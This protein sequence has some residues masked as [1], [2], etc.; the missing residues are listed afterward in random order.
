MKK[1]GIIFNPMVEAAGALAGELERYL[2][3]AGVS[4][5]S[6]S[7]WELA[8]I[9]PEVSGTDLVLSVGGDGTILRA[10]Q[11]V[12]A[13]K[14]PIT[15]I[16]LGKLGFMTELAADEALNRLPE[17]LDGAGWLDERAMLEAQITGNG[18]EGKIYYA[19]NDVVVARGAIARLVSVEA[20][21]DDEPL[22]V[23][24]ADGVMV[25]TATGSTGYALAAGGPV[26]SPEVTELLLLPILP[27]LSLSYPLVLPA[28]AVVSLRVSTAYRATLS[29]DGNINLPLE[30]GALIT[31]KRSQVITRFWRIHPRASFYRSLEQKLKGKK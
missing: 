26:L 18:G 9:R 8:E 4:S 16:N 11:A 28:R 10:V 31:V 13:T 20:S 25:A 15:G 14:T 22:T 29:V 12:I 1:V 6:C 30:S 23:Y 17:I 7:S 24:R 2:A 21:V 3:G 5:W 27:H 19:L